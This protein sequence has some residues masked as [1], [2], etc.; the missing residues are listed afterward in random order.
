MH[1]LIKKILNARVYDVAV[2]SPLELMPRLSAR[3]GNRVFLK[4]ED[5]QPVFSFKLRGAY[6][7]MALLS[8]A[9]KKGGVI[10]A[11]AGNHAQ[12]VAFSARRMG[13][14]AT[15]VMPRSTPPIKVQAVENLGGR[16][17]LTGDTFDEAFV[18]AKKLEWEQNLTFIH[19]FDDEDVIAGQGTI[20]KEML[21]QQPD[22]TA[23][24]VPVGGGGLVA[25]I[26]SYIKFLRP[27]VKVYGVE[28]VE[29]ASMHDSLAAGERVSL[30][31]V[32]IFADGVAVRQVG[33]TTFALCRELLDGVVLV[34]TDQICAAMKD[35]FDDTRAISEPSGALAVAGAKKYLAEH[36]LKNQ[37]VAAVNS[38]ANVNFDR[39]RHVAERAELGEEREAIFAVTIPERP[40]AFKALITPLGDRNITEFNY[41]YASDTDAQVFIGLQTPGGR[42][43]RHEV[44]ALFQSAGYPVT[45]LS[46]D[47]MAKI[48]IRYMVGGKAKGV[49]DERVFHFEF[50]ERQGALLRFLNSLT[51][52]WNI[53]L[54]H[55]RNHGSDYGRV[56]C[57]IQVPFGDNE[58]FLAVITAL[59]Y[60][61]REETQNPAYR[62]FLSC[63]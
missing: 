44:L 23:V 34:E 54:F 39:L 45:D 13:V 16:V 29:A 10:C 4:R 24:F 9:E 1:S 18:H 49:C 52:D 15:I 59:G 31:Q 33:E 25:G 58:R 50:P 60:S 20:G 48:H 40:G 2:K 46:N 57:G 6:N 37:C 36:G 22:L 17:V 5:L 30:S 55:Y 21:E 7:R 19:P 61:F 14:E 11:S 53:S 43:E 12:G 3:S 56:L 27:E 47:E 38:G 26:A 63:D 42:A 35:I 8:D 62:F 41:R 51:S 32:G 28:P